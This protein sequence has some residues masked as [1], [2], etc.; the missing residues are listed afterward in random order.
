MRR[1][2][3][4]AFI[5]IGFSAG[6][7]QT[8]SCSQTLRLARSTYDQGRLHEVATLMEKCL[9]GGFTQQEKVEAYKLLCLTYLYLEEPEKA[10]DAMLN[11]LRTDPY[12]EVNKQVD[13]A[14]FIALYRT[15]RTQP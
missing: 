10:D 9:K 5:A 4:T 15:F 6:F 1:I 13:P 3:L 2:L 11:L 8:T 7:A 12:F 14:E